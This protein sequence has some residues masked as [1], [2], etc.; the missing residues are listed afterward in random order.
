MDSIDAANKLV[1]EFGVTQSDALKAIDAEVDDLR[2]DTFRSRK[3]T[4]KEALEAA[5]ES[6]SGWL[7]NGDEYQV[8]L[9]WT[10]IR[11]FA[12]SHRKACVWAVLTAKARAAQAQSGTQTEVQS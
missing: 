1:K 4:Y 6:I 2:N 7:K 10:D 3:S 12:I 8:K 9:E 5:Y 11:D